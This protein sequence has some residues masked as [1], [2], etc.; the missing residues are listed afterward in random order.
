M[1]ASIKKYRQTKKQTGGSGESN[2]GDWVLVNSTGKS[3][4]NSLTR[5]F[6]ALQLPSTPKDKPYTLKGNTEI[7]AKYKFPKLDYYIKNINAENIPLFNEKDDY[8]KLKL[9]LF[10]TE[11]KNIESLVK[12]L[13][14]LNKLI[15]E[16][17]DTLFTVKMKVKDKYRN[18]VESWITFYYKLK[19]LLLEHEVLLIHLLR[20]SSNA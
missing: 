16:K 4:T 15:T 12:T 6:K 13:Q 20:E 10:K 7:P 9:S 8:I 19:N 17:T 11:N 5:R 18:N 2:N 3:L 1:S 14:E